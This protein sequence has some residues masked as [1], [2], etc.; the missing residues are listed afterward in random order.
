MFEGMVR[1]GEWSTWLDKEPR[2]AEYCRMVDPLADGI[3]GSRGDG[4]RD[5][6]G[7]ELTLADPVDGAP[8]QKAA[9]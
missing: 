9:L 8:H 2:R 4:R 6:R 1:R 5:W 3:T 7:I